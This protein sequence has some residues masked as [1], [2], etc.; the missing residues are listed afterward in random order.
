MTKAQ[1][2]RQR[3]EKHLREMNDGMYSKIMA[4]LEQAT[5]TGKTSIYWYKSIPDEV[6]SILTDNEHGF[7]IQCL[8]DRNDIYY[9]IDFGS[10]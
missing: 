10:I 1:E 5:S 6:Q 2:L 9:K 8:H 7:E 4:E 3:A